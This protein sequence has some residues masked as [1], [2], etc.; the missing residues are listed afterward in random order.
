MRRADLVGYGIH[1]I[2]SLIRKAHGHCDTTHA[3]ICTG[4][5]EHGNVL[6]AHVTGHK[7]MRYVQEPLK[8]MIN[9]D[10]DGDRAFM[11]YRPKNKD[12]SHKISDVAGDTH[13]NK[14]LR[15]RAHTAAGSVLRVS[16]LNPQREISANKAISPD[17]F[18][19]KFVVQ[20]IKVATKPSSG[21][22]HKNKSKY[23]PHL[24]SSCT[25]K[26]LESYLYQ[27]KNYDMLVYPGKNNP[28]HIIQQ[29][30]SEQLTRIRKRTDL[31]SRNKYQ[32]LNNQFNESCRELDNAE[33]D[34]LQ[35]SVLLIKRLTPAL[36]INRGFNFFTPKSYRDVIKK[37]RSMAIF[38][39]DINKK[40]Q[41]I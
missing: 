19:T 32:E 39:R 24:R 18:C 29:E 37:A 36:K 40:P 11:V 31:A 15:Y 16:H 33:I 21:L 14:N 28:Y 5:D 13:A 26:T 22:L 23:Y 2:Q 3:G 34:D 38:E 27:D 6:I 9:R 10:S 17:T 4:K 30:I 35:K 8:D 25:P 7:I 20:S 1:F 12:I 41:K